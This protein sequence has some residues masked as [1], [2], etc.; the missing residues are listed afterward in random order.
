M[1]FLTTCSEHCRNTKAF[2]SVIPASHA[3]HPEAE[4]G[5]ELAE[6]YLCADA[7]R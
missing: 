1:K 2:G 5:F 3:R 4:Y 6:I 7:R